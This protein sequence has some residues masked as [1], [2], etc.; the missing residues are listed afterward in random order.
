MSVE[1]VKEGKNGGF[2]GVGGFFGSCFWRVFCGKIH[3]CN[4]LIFSELRNGVLG[5]FLLESA[6]FAGLNELRGIE[7]EFKYKD[8]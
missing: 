3:N 2:W 4:W 6:N 7:C 1:R 8:I 5:E